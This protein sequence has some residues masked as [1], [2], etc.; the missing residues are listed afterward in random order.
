MNILGFMKCERIDAATA[1][2]H[3]GGVMERLVGR[4]AINAYAPEFVGRDP[5]ETEDRA[6]SCAAEA[7]SQPL[8]GTP[9]GRPRRFLK[10][11][12]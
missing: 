12:K 4:A 3:V 10:L 7:R 8:R 5:R 11:V 6:P 9:G 1:W 2:Q